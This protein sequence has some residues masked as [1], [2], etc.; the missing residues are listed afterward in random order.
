[1]AK[2]IKSLLIVS[3][4][5]C[6]FAVRGAESASS[7]L[8][9]VR[10]RFTSAPSVEA[11]FTISGAGSPMQGSAI[12]AG[13][14]FTFTT[15]QLIVWFDGKTQWAYM[16]SSKEVNISEPETDE[17]MAANP[18]AIL[19]S[20][21][22]YYTSLRIAD[23]NGLQRVRLTPR[24]KNSEIDNIVVGINPSTGWPKTVTV[25]FADKRTVDL[26]IDKISAGNAR[27]AS[28]FR[29]DKALYPASDIIDLR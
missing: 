18:F 11:L 15:P 4:L 16:K 24:D 20:N 6:S 12:M 1:M 13:P 8:D 10:A 14:S 23:K 17:I 2:S 19:T 25:T 27:N 9:K 5:L 22:S 21:S 7:I 3:L 28:T 26:N 29:Y